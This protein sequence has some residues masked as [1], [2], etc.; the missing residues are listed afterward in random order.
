ML[1]LILNWLLRS[2]EFRLY[3]SRVPVGKQWGG[4]DVHGVTDSWLVLYVS[5]KGQVLVSGCWQTS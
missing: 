3:G 2:A 1:R 5:V 4:H